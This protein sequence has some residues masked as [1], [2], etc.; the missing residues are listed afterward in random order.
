MGSWGSAMN[1][2]RLRHREG[3]G[4]HT[5]II[6]PAIIA[7]MIT[8]LCPVLMTVLRRRRLT[9]ALHSSSLQPCKDYLMMCLLT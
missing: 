7:S 1:A 4:F 5:V 3:E 6:K 9:Y 2:S 8:A